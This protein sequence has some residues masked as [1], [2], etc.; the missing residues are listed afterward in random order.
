MKRPPINVGPSTVTVYLASGPHTVQKSQAVL[1]AIKA[2]DWGALERLAKP[3]D[4]IGH[5]LA[6]HG[7]VSVTGGHV[8]F[9]GR[10]V[11]NASAGRI[12]DMV[13]DGL[14][15]TSEVLCLASLMRHDDP[16]VIASFEDYLERWRIPRASDG[17]IVLCKGVR[18]DFMSTHRGPSGHVDWTPGKPVPR[19]SWDYVDR[20][21]NQSCS[22]G[23]HAAPLEGA[24]SYAG[25][26]GHL[27]EV[28]VAPEDIAAFPMDYVQ[29]GKLRA[30]Y[31]EAVRVIPPNIAARYYDLRDTVRDV[32]DDWGGDDFADD[33][34]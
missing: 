7:D 28:Y 27:L 25:G 30:V 29:N 8:Y 34:Y 14:D 10:V 6:R 33:D 2:A 15:V 13:R 20:D 1:D 26:G 17:R 5:A 11:N 16:R 21:P 19:L 32:S 22:K 24:Q 18:A 23:Y 9:R 4:F 3:A 12:L 31:M